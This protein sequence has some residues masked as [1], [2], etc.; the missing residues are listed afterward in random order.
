MIF[1]TASS[2]A[3]ALLLCGAAWLVP[4]AWAVQPCPEKAQVGVL[5]TVIGQGHI[6]AG[7]HS[8][9]AE[10]GAGVCVGERIETSAG[11]HVHIR[12]VDGAL[13]SVRPSSRLHIEAYPQAAAGPV[14]FRLEA[15]VVRAVSGE[16]SRTQREQF[17]LNT[18]LAA[19]GIKGTDFVVRADAHA[20]R[21]TVHSGAIVVAPLAGACALA[22]QHCPD[23]ALTLSADMSHLMIELS[24]EHPL[25]R[26]L[27]AL[28]LLAAAAG[29]SQ[30]NGP[31]GN[32]SNGNAAAAATESSEQRHGIEA[33]A[34]HTLVK[35]APLLRWAHWG[36]AGSDLP[37]HSISQRFEVALFAGLSPTV[38]S[39]SYTLFRDE[40]TL[41]HFS[42]QATATNFTLRQGQAHFYP[43]L[44][45]V[46]PPEV[47]QIERGQLQVDFAHATFATQLDLRGPGGSSQFAVAG[48]I[49][50]HGRFHASGA[51]QT[52]AGAFATDG[53]QAGYLFNQAVPHG[54]ISGI[55]LWG[56]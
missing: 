19:I 44:S 54:H 56:R 35:A 30:P 25:P 15:G 28:D 24:R 40:R 33:Q 39:L 17:R 16:F 12:F 21:A 20:T 13:V 26:L 8:R 18:P 27:P 37:P 43:T 22:P 55:T 50:S 5:G 6:H 31:N 32:G 42:P 49:D 4:A 2:R 47:L 51:G 3:Q 46:H 7:A 48:S 10:R 36:A 52:L 53:S 38:G 34:Q 29:R 1:Q 11:G 41:G 14:R 45:W 23:Q 9:P